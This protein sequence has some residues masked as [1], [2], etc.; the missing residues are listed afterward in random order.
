[1]YDS[2][3][4]YRDSNND[5]RYD[6]FD[7]HDFYSQTTD[8]NV[9]VNAESRVTADP[10][11]LYQGPQDARRHTIQGEI[12]S[13]KMV[14]VNGSQNL[15]VGVSGTN[16]N[17]LAIDLG[18][19]ESLKG[20]NVE[21]GRSIV[22]IG[23]METIGEKDLLLADSFQID[24][25]QFFEVSRN[26][27]MSITGQIVDIMS[28]KI[29]ANDHYIAIVDVDGDRQLV[30]FGPTAMYKVQLEPATQVTVVGMPVRTQDDRV[31]LANQVQVGNEVIEIDHTQRFTR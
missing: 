26:A 8:A 12:A 28:T 7:R 24:D 11:T 25:G 29:D 18:H 20:Y 4:Y 17:T 22:A 30:D 2:H 3:S 9:A 27:G 6:E 15:L 14:Q 21:V 1:V 31:I 13:T 19:A 10:G 16:E 23:A 5:G